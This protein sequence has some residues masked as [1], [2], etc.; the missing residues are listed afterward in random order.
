ML[1]VPV[2]GRVTVTTPA[3]TAAVTVAA[4]F[5]SISFMPRMFT[6]VTAIVPS[7]RHALNAYA[8]SFP[9]RVSYVIGELL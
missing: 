2:V 4:V 6:L 1:P 5:I 9:A 7:L 8:K 3:A